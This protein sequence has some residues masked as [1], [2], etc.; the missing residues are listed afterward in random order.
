MGEAVG[1][2]LFFDHEQQRFAAAIR[3][4]DQRWHIEFPQPLTEAFLQLLLA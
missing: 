1:L 3:P 2:R 4:L